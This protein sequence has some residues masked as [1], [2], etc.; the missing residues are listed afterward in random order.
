MINVPN[1]KRYTTATRTYYTNLPCSCCHE[2][3]H[4]FISEIYMRVKGF[5]TKDMYVPNGTGTFAR[6][7]LEPIGTWEATKRTTETFDVNYKAT[8]LPE[9][10][11]DTSKLLSSIEHSKIL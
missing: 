11:R 7:Q 5:Q 4:K 8:N 1:E 10:V 2:T 9:V 6:N 3:K